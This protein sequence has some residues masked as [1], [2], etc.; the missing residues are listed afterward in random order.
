MRLGQAV[1]GTLVY[2]TYADNEQVFPAGTHVRGSIVGL[3]A[4]K[5]H[6]LQAR[7]R[8]DFTPFSHP[9]VQFR[10]VILP[11]GTSMPLPLGTASD[12]APV[13]QLTP[14]PP[15]KGGFIRREFH[16][17]VGLVKDRVRLITAPGK[18]DR[19]KDLLYSQLPY[20][21]QRIVAGTV[22]TVETTAG[23]DV[24]QIVVPHET[25]VVAASS[26]PQPSQTDPS[27]T[28]TLEAY[29]SETVT[30]RKTH[31]GDAIHAVVA[32]PFRDTSTG[33]IE[34]PQGA[35]L[36]GEV[37]RARPA[38]RFGRAGDLRFGFRQLTFPGSPVPQDVQTSLA[39]I[40]AVGGSNLALDRE[41][42]VTPKPKD[43]LAV[44]VLLFA[45]AARP[46]DRDRGDNGFGKDAVAS[47]SLGVLGFIVGT[48]G[49]WRN[50]AAGIGYYGTAISV[51]NRWI[52]RGDETT[53]RKDTRVVVQ[54]TARRSAPMSVPGARTPQ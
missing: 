29:L 30:S 26:N 6:R 1:E 14:P 50:V 12:G 45:L 47:N 11:D 39:G 36:E 18:T 42:K 27:H 52:K 31:V 40:D 33:E 34:V 54:T 22:W 25:P 28:W 10:E 48:A 8:G 44:P 16:T 9:V 13:L 35:V 53:L 37:T 32:R 41:G 5:P 46:L 17:G 19:L 20:H 21:P 23:T 38:R 3:L 43:R 4:D 15:S 51:W 49:G 7:L 2:P 24:P